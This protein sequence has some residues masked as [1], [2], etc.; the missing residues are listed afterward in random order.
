MRLPDLA[1][2]A[3]H[4]AG[5]VIVMDDFG[6]K[7]PRA[8]ATDVKGTA[9]WPSPLL[10]TPTPT[11]PDPGE[12]PRFA[13]TASAVYA[14]G[15][16]AELL[17]LGMPWQGPMHYPRQPDYQMG[18]DMMRPYFGAHSSAGHAWAQRAALNI[19][20]TRWGEVQAIARHLIEHGEW[21]GSS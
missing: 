7:S 12:A 6:I 8:V 9:F 5:H 14:A 18:E 16:M 21:L 17:Y 20:Q 4:E 2:V 3:H 13:A 15:V 1:R 10:T 11:A 19:L